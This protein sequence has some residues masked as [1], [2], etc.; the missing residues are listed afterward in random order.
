MMDSP[1]LWDRDTSLGSADQLTHAL[2]LFT[3]LFV[4]EESFNLTKLNVCVSKD[5]DKNIH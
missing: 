5:S 4:L 2:D 3:A 1:A